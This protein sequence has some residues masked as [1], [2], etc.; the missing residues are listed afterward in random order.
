ANALGLGAAQ[1]R[2]G[3][4]AVVDH[5]AGREALL[6]LDNCEHL[7]DAVGVFVERVLGRCPEVSIP[8]TSQ[9]RLM[10]PFEWVFPVPGRSL[11]SPGAGEPAGPDAAG[12]GVGPGDGGPPTGGMPPDDPSAEDPSRADPPTDDATGDAVAL[13]VERARQAGAGELAADSPDRI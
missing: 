5:L 9:A 4:D 3:E 13:F 12:A 11:P 10:L 1:G 7:A 2:S 6:V 8:A